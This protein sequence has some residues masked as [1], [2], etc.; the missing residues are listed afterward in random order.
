MLALF[1]LDGTVTR[2]DTLARYLAGF[3]RDHPAR[4]V[5][6]PRALPVLARFLAGAADRG[7]LKS[8]LITT[9]LGGCTRPEIEAW[10]ERFVPAV[11]ER[12]V[13]AD[14]LHAIAGHREA[15]DLLV[16]L[17]ASPDLY[18]PRIGS[19]LGF[20]ET[21]CT[22]VEWRDGRITGRLTTANRRGAE[23]ARCLAELRTRHP[24]LPVVAYGNAA[25]DLAHLSL[26]TSGI[27]VN[28]GPRARRAAARL[29]VAHVRW[30]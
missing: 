30:R 14:A 20:A 5:R 6:L 13:R 15:G 4:A 28:G 16:L 7:E 18:V 8:G 10:T 24:G 17:S 3:L 12:G 9:V 19:A 29:G 27:L 23:K 26:A 11:I 1:D 25:S 2:G 21:I 22:G